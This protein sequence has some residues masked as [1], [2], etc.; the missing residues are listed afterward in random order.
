[1][2]A[3]PAAPV[4]CGVVVHADGDFATSRDFRYREAEVV[5]GKAGV[6][7]AD[8]ATRLDLGDGFWIG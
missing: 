8:V 2:Q 3:C 6:K 7:G 4:P 5:V 1:M